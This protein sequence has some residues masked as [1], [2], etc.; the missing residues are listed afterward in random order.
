MSAYG[1]AKVRVDEFQQWTIL[2]GGV[3][4][5]GVGGAWDVHAAKLPQTFFFVRAACAVDRIKVCP[6][7]GLVHPAP[8]VRSQFPP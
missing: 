7:D 3:A 5:K 6:G 8:V 1:V 2:G 4:A